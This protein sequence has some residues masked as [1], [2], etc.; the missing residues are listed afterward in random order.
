MGGR[1]TLLKP[2]IPFILFQHSKTISK[3]RGWGRQ[4]STV[5][6]SSK[7][8]FSKQCPPNTYL[9][10][11]RIIFMQCMWVFTTPYCVLA[12]SVSIQVE[13]CFVRKKEIVQQ[14]NVSLYQKK[15][16]K[17]KFDYR[18]SE[19]MLANT[20][21]LVLYDSANAGSV[22]CKWEDS[23]LYACFSKYVCL[24]FGLCLIR[25]NIYDWW[26]TEC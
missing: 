23:I 13:P 26:T 22:H 10:R 16:T 6:F 17:N 24:I 21:D 7:N 20:I 8:S 1:P 18:N 3:K 2:T 12:I 14:V 9:W 19:K 4:F 11:P 5:I 25:H 15:K